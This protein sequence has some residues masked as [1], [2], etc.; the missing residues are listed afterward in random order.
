MNHEIS[1]IEQ[2]SMR[3]KELLAYKESS[4][5]LARWEPVRYMDSGTFSHVFLVRNR[6]TG[7]EAVLKF[8]PN[9]MDQLACRGEGSQEDLFY[10]TRFAAARREAEIMGRFRGEAH[11]VQYL[12]APEYLKRSFANARMETV[13]QYVVLICMPLY[14]N[15]REWL[16]LIAGDRNA[17]LRLGIEISEALIAFEEKGVYHRDIKPGNILMDDE[18]H[19]CLSDVGEAKL[20]SEFTT[21]GFHGTRPYMA[22]EVYN[23]ENERKKMHSDHRSDIYS[24]G[25]ILYRLFNRG[26]FPFLQESGE[27][28]VDARTTFKSYSK[29]YRSEE[30]DKYLTDS[31]RA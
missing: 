29:K 11:V 9:P 16:P 26:Q 28:T 14:K 10:Q 22:P 12:E 8:I 1:D 19:F 5:I 3:L 17:R 24:L 27:L 6:Q 31:E 25:I 7:T 18:G 20:E 13:R 21:T 4:R 15:H 2:Q 23:Q 30:N